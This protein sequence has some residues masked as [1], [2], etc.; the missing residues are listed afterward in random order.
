MSEAML[1]LFQI[2]EV[3]LI[4]KGKGDHNRPVVQSATE[5]YVVL[6]D[7]WDANKIELLEQ[8]KVLLLDTNNEVLAISE[9]STGG[10]AG[11]VADP[12]LI[13]ATALKA[14]AASIIIAHNHPSG[15]L[16][17]STADLELTRKLANAGN[18]LDIK[19]LDHLI[20][21]RNS[22]HSMQNEGTWPS[23]F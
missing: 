10:I 22:F 16:N 20:L 11:T 5:A 17:P 7:H 8:F 12:K 21:S 18:F 1:N 4:Y 2:T 3:E 9:L 15:S 6:R 14:R 13:F 19:V 23:P